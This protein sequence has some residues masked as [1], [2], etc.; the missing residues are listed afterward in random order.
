MVQRGRICLRRL[1]K[2]I[3]HKKFIRFCFFNSFARIK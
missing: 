1:L 2:R 3:N